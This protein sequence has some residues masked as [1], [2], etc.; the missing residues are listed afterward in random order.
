MNICSYVQTYD[1]TEGMRLS[2]RETEGNFK[3]TLRDLRECPLRSD[4]EERRSQLLTV[5]STLRWVTHTRREHEECA[6]KALY[7]LA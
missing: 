2:L 6:I 4:R 3:P 7:V 5:S 1:S